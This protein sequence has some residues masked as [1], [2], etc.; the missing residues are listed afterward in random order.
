MTGRTTDRKGKSKE[1]KSLTNELQNEIAAFTLP[2]SLPCSEINFPVAPRRKPRA[3][4]DE[5]L[6]ESEEKFQEVENYENSKKGRQPLSPFLNTECNYLK[7]KVFVH[8]Q[9]ALE[10]TLYKAQIWEAL[11]QQK[12]F[13]N[14]IDHI[15]QL[16]WNNNPRHPQRKEHNLHIFNMPWVRELLKTNP[17]AYYPKSWLWPEDYAATVIQ[18]TVRQY[19]VQREDEVQE[20]RNFWRKLE[21]ERSIPEIQ[22]NPLLSKKFAAS[23]N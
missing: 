8:L 18:K 1:L 15:A 23:Q 5:I 16:L 22:G 21:V 12:C 13:F 10:E 19:F 9:P 4:W 2:N 11:K 14:G 3:N 20:M 7:E 17:R 6:E